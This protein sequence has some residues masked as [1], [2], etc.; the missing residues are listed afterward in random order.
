[1]SID[2]IHDKLIKYLLDS[3]MLARHLKP[4]N[5]DFY[6]VIVGG[7]NVSRCAMLQ[8][9]AKK[10]LGQLSL[11]DIDIGF[12]IRQEITDNSH[13]LVQMAHDARMKFLTAL[14][15]DDEFVRFVRGFAEQNNT[16]I[17]LSI[18]M[19]QPIFEFIGKVRL[20]S[21]HA[22]YKLEDGS[23]VSRELIDTSILSNYADKSDLLYPVYIGRSLVNPIPYFKQAGLPYAT[24]NFI[25]FDTVRVLSENL[26]FLRD[27]TADLR[28]QQKVIKY[29]AKFCIMYSQVKRLKGNTEFK[30]IL[31]IYKEARQVMMNKEI[32]LPEYKGEVE[33]LKY[34][35]EKH[36]TLK[37]IQNAIVG[38]EH[39]ST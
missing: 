37:E 7:V 14:I 21:L 35:L 11:H 23:T 9:K 6:P 4:G 12:V 34:A 38:L 33:K 3:G 5:S 27:G 13:E 19:Y 32:S 17:W 15:Y 28:R 26:G 31:A 29:I 16:F 18:N 36:T 22:K 2:Q 39:G 25:F 8:P 24:C 20:V 1:M 30:K 10:L